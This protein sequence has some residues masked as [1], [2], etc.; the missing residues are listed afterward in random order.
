VH[1]EFVPALADHLL[2]GRYELIGHD[3]VERARATLD[4][5]LDRLTVARWMVTF[6]QRCLA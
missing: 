1:P 4:R 2:A 6:W 5:P 3:T